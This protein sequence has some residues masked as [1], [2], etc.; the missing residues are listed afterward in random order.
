MKTNE[1]TGEC[2]AR[3]TLKRGAIKE[4]RA[5][6]PEGDFDIRQT[7]LKFVGI[8]ES[9]WVN[10]WNYTCNYWDKETRLCTAYEKRPLMCSEFPYDGICGVCGMKG[11]KAGEEA[12]LV[13]CCSTH[14]I[15]YSGS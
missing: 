15:Q 13:W 8:D 7:M 1:C 14:R 12:Q 2:C 3:F 5:F 11:P 6:E 9:G 10:E 4:F